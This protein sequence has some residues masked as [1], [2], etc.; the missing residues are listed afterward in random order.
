M[1]AGLFLYV[2]LSD[3]TIQAY[4]ASNGGLLGVIPPIF[5]ENQKNEPIQ[6]VT[7]L[8]TI[9]SLPPT[10]T[11]NQTKSRSHSHASSQGDTTNDEKKFNNKKDEVSLMDPQ[12][13]MVCVTGRVIKVITSG[14]QHYQ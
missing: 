7:F 11:M 1:L 10:I 8:D 4:N 13:Y 2:A 14:K 5:E 3:G 12:Q 9:T 6:P